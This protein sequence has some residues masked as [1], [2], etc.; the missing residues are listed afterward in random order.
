MRI[1]LGARPGD[2]LKMI[3]R[4]GLILAGIGIAA[5]AALA[6]AAGMGLRALLAGVRPGDAATFASAIA[7]C[8]LMTLA[9]SLIPAVRAVRVD[10]AAA[11]PDGIIAART[12]P[13]SRR[14]CFLSGLS[15]LRLMTGSLRVSKTLSVFHPLVIWL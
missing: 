2:I 1:A 10:P 5:G 15:I 9:G 14:Y 13:G 3:V 8:L 11:S 4:D 12:G 7:L 6:Y